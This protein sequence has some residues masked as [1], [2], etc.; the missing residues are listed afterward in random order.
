MLTTYSM[1]EKLRQRLLS[2][3]LWLQDLLHEYGRREARRLHGRKPTEDE[4]QIE[5][6]RIL[7]QCVLRIMVV[8]PV[9]IAVAFRDLGTFEPEAMKRIV[10][11]PQ[12]FLA[13]QYGGGKFKLNFYYQD[14]FVA[15]KNFVIEGPERWRALLGRAPVVSTS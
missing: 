15:T 6:L 8:E 10:T 14:T 5:F 3:P 13:E 12:G 7:P 2:S 11:D 4:I 9:G 1:D